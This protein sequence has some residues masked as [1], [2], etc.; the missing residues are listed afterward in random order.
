V[1]FVDLFVVHSLDRKHRLSASGLLGLGTTSPASAS[2]VAA[3][4]RPGQQL[5]GASFHGTSEELF[6][7]LSSIPGEGSFLPISVSLGICSSASR[8][9]S[10]ISWLSG[11]RPT[12]SSHT[13]Q[14]YV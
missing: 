13:H 4:D 11:F 1:L 2:F 9:L 7:L 5:E 3:I 12:C 8:Q 14:V 6:L 10:D